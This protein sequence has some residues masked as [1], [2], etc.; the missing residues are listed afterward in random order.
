MKIEVWSD[1]VCPFCYI[2][3]R[4]LEEALQQAGF[5]SQAEVEFK[6]FELD[7]TSPKTSDKSMVEVLAEKYGQSVEAAKQ[8]TAGVAEQ[9]KTVGLNYNF[10][11]M[12][13]ANT[14]DAHRL[15][16]WA[17]EQ[18]KA[19]EA[20]E[21]LLH[22]YFIE[23]K[24]IGKH[25]VL[26]DLIESLGLPRE[27]AEKVLNSD[28]YLTEVRL[29]IARAGQIGVRGVPFFVLNDKYA[30]SGAQPLESFIGALNKVAEE[31]G[32]SPAQ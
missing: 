21:L 4:R 19:K 2:G 27:E 25:E 1:F 26:L 8:M 11:D 22:A 20:N 3:K 29:D 32:I 18:G 13:P 16:K 28:D 12:K 9:A 23:A 15:V 5:E 17:S 7:P 6:S 30:I 24:E 10:D 31:E 14:L